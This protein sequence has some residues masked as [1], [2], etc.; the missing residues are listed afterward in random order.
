MATKS[1]EDHELE[2]GSVV[3]QSNDSFQVSFLMLLNMNRR[4][5]F[6]CTQS[7]LISLCRKTRV[8]HLK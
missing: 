1:C 7:C 5:T 4:A 2:K 6:I 3:L 8:Y